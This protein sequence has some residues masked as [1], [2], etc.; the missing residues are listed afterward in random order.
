M[1]TLNVTQAPYTAD[2]TTSAD[3]SA[4]IQ[5]AMDDANPGDVVYIPA[6]PNPGV[7]KYVLAPSGENGLTVN[8]THS[9]ITIL[10]DGFDSHL[11][12]E[13]G[14]T[15]NYRGLKIDGSA[16][17]ITNV[18]IESIRLDG[19]KA[20]N[21][22]APNSWGIPVF[23]N[24]NAS[25]ADDNIVIQ[26]CWT[27]DWI[28]TGMEIS[29]G[30]IAQY[31]TS[32]DNTSHGFATSYAENN[33][34]INR[35]DHC[36]TYGNGLYGID[37][38]GRALITNHRSV[39]DAYGFKSSADFG[40][41]DGANQVHECRNS[42]F[43]DVAVYGYQQT[44]N[45]TSIVLEDVEVEN[46][47]RNGFRFQYDGDIY[48]RGNGIKAVNT[49]TGTSGGGAILF[50]GANTQ[51]V[52][53]E[54]GVTSIIRVDGAGNEA[55]VETR[56]GSSGNV[57]QLYWN[58]ATQGLYTNGGSVT[59][60]SVTQ[61]ATVGD[62]TYP[63]LAEVGADN[64]G[65]VNDLAIVSSTTIAFTATDV[66]IAGGDRSPNANDGFLKLNCF[67]VS[68]D[69]GQTVQN[70]EYDLNAEVQIE[71]IVRYEN[72]WK[73]DGITFIPS[74]EIYTLV[75]GISLLNDR[76]M[77][78]IEILRTQFSVDNAVGQQLDE[79]VRPWG[80]NRRDGESDDR[81]RERAIFTV[82]ADTI[83]P[84][85]DSYILFLAQLNGTQVT[86]ITLTY[87]AT[88]NPELTVTVDQS[89]IETNLS[90]STRRELAQRAL[91]VGHNVTVNYV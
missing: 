24:D 3:D 35:I 84:D 36:Y 28:T 30:A 41:T 88:D 40:V 22:S 16:N 53:D 77:E 20:N 68:V 76:L 8:E 90:T 21:G 73:A 32:Y 43:E 1:A 80:I 58:N 6:V 89:A 83:R 49:D 42:K 61:T 87:D 13:G 78:D 57:D 19:N 27:H 15:S 66:S 48:I 51:N 46:V 85:F 74:K 33:T 64:F 54:A 50:G 45:I 55:A 25:P 31:C 62:V 63:T 38:H 52:I 67:D 75:K 34:N 10:G 7:D 65:T 70:S 91:P 86:D 39:G 2:P 9:G 26:G 23:A 4:T 69:G 71:A 18:T 12:F 14:R 60:D 47:V 72:N 5:Q 44:K 82:Y 17:D 81:L 37:M 59:I 11:Q 79:V 29:R 56:V